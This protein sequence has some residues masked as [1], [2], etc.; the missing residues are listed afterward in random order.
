[1]HHA[2]ELLQRQTV[3]DGLD[4]QAQIRAEDGLPLLRPPAICI[5]S[6]Q[7]VASVCVH[8]LRILRPAGAAIRQGMQQASSARG[9]QRTCILV[10]AQSSAAATAARTHASHAPQACT[11]SEVSLSAVLVAAASSTLHSTP[12]MG[13]L[14]YTCGAVW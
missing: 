10:S 4:G 13:S 1:M 11:H 2:P 6:R 7:E 9:K 14:L 5:V 8:D 3:P 12:K